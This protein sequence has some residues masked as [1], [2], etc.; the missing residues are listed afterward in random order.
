VEAA[1][2]EPVCVNSQTVTQQQVAETADSKSVED[3]VPGIHSN[4]IDRHRLT[5]APVVRVDRDAFDFA[6]YIAKRWINLPPHVRETIS[7]LLEQFGTD[8][9]EVREAASNR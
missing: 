9:C 6:L 7:T 8:E 1:G 2:I 4:G 5:T 3:Y